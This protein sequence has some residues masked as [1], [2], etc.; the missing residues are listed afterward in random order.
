MSNIFVDEGI[1]GNISAKSDDV[2]VSGIETAL[3]SKSNACK[4]QRRVL[5]HKLFDAESNCNNVGASLMNTRL[6]DIE[7]IPVW[8]ELVH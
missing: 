1:Q 4:S 6:I 7:F 8:D 3:K 5:T 2:S